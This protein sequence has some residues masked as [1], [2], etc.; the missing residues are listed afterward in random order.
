MYIF[1]LFR[2]FK[3]TLLLLSI[4]YDL[5]SAHRLVAV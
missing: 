4:V 3:S 1:L 2:E 5:F